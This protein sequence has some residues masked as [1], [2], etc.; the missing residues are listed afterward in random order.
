MATSNV[1]KNSHYISRF[2]LRNWAHPKT[3]KV[4]VFDFSSGSF[5]PESTKRTYVA[6]EAF[7]PDVETWLKTHIEDPLGEYLARV[8]RTKPPAAGKK[9]ALPDP[10]EREWKAIRLWTLTQSLRTAMARDPSDN[11]LVELVR[12]PPYPP[13]GG[14]PLVE[15][16]TFADQLLL[17]NEERAASFIVFAAREQLYFP[18]AGIVGLPLVNGATFAFFVPLHPRVFAAVV[19]R[20]AG[21][22]GIQATLHKLGLASALSSGLEGDLVVIPPLRDDADMKEVEAHLRLARDSA[23]AF[24]RIVLEQQSF[25][26][27]KLGAEWRPPPVIAPE[28]EG[29]NDDQ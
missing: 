7:P 20:A 6:D 26:G 16:Q 14:G 25:L 4:T 28:E 21:D 24:T 13:P 27:I 12:T 9:F 10:T 2:A 8:K 15:G 22:G 29:T 1:V 19:P 11:Q 5:V 23:R 18:E 3:G 17:A